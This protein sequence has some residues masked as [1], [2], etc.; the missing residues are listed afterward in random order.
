MGLD[1]HVGRTVAQDNPSLKGLVEA[2][3]ILLPSLAQAE[4]DTPN[5]TIIEIETYIQ[6]Y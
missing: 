2:K 1:E 4:Q 3:D 6:H 5:T